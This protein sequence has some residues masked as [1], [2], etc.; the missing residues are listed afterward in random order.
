MT[1][2]VGVLRAM[3]VAPFR[4]KCYPTARSCRRLGVTDCCARRPKTAPG[5]HHRLGVM[6]ESIQP[7]RCQEWIAK[8]LGPFGRGPVARQDDAPALIALR[9]HVVH[10]LWSG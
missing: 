8:Q 2:T 5:Y 10:V 1:Q 3:V 7:G 6:G 9:N 4:S